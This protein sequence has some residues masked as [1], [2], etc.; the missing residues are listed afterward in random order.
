MWL[1]PKTGNVIGELYLGGSLKDNEDDSIGLEIDGTEECEA[2]PEVECEY[3]V[4]D[5]GIPE[6]PCRKDCCTAE[7]VYENNGPGIET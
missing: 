4:D 6:C 1:C 3:N 2:H 5:E 7:E